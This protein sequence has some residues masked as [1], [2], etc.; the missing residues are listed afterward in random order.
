MFYL[1]K[2][3]LQLFFVKNMFKVSVL[4]VSCLVCRKLVALVSSES[5]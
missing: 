5:L 4:I 2:S 3:A 1:I